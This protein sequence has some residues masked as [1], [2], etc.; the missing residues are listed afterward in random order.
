MH[1]RIL[2][3]IATVLFGFGSVSNAQDVNM[4]EKSHVQK[5]TEYEV[6]VTNITHGQSFTPILLATHAAEFHLF[7]LGAPIRPDLAVL[8]QEGFV[9]P[10][11][12]ALDAD[13]RVSSTVAATGLTRFGGSMRFVIGTRKGFERLSLAAMLIPTND[14]F[15]A[16]DGLDLT[17]V[18][19][20]GR[21]MLVVA[22]DAGAEINDELCP[23]LPST[24]SFP[25]CGG[26]GGGQVVGNGEGYVH[27]HN[28]IHGIGD[29][30][31]WI[32]TWQNPVATVRVRR[33]R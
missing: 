2:L 25:E 29:L 26:P 15:M 3:G 14:S 19:E 31:P 16:L 18:D 33:L 17:D 11:R 10:L 8:A 1:R 7:E 30:V 32:R 23:S 22:Y 28:G 20:R 6:V 5:T 27:I 12:P 24:P 4:S 13:P 9:S 21:T